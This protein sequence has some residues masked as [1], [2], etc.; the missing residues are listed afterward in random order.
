MFRRFIQEI[1]PRNGR[2]LMVLIV[3][4]IS[5]CQNQK[6]ASLDDQLDN[7]KALIREMYGDDRLVKFVVISTTGKGEHLDRSELT[8]V[9]TAMRS[10]IYD[11]TMYD[12]LSRLIRGEYAKTLLG[13]GKD[14]GTR[15]ISINDG[16]DTDDPTWEEDALT[17]CAENV[18]HQ[19]RTSMRIKQ[20]MMNRFKK[21]GGP[22]G[23]LLP[24][25]TA[26]EGAK[27]YMDWSK[28]DEMTPILQE[29][30][31]I[32]LRGERPNYGAVV[33]HFVEKNAP[34]GPY[35]R[36]GQWN[37]VM[38]RNL[39]ANPILKGWPERGKRR[40]VKHNESG[41]RPSQKNPEGGTPFHARHLA[42]FSE[43]VFDQLNAY[44]KAA[45]AHLGR[46]ASDGTLLLGRARGSSVFPGLHARCWYCGFHYVWGANGIPDKLMCRNVRARQ[47]WHSIG[48]SG[49][50]LTDRLSAE[51]CKELG[52]LDGFDEQFTALV[53]ESRRHV[54]DQFAD[55]WE[56][57]RRDETKFARDKDNLTASIKAAGPRPMLI[58][59]LDKIEI[60]EQK[61]L[62]RRHELENCSGRQLL[63]PPSTSALRQM[64]EDGLRELPAES[65]EFNDLLRKLVPEI[66]VYAVRMCD[67]GNLL[68]RAKVTLNLGG[69]FPDIN[70]VPGAADLLRR[71]LTID[72][73]DP[74]QRERIREE[75]ARSTAD[76]LTQRQIAATM[77][78]K[79]TIDMI[80]DA[81]AL[82]TR[83]DSLGITS[84]YVVMLEPPS[85]YPKLKR[86]LHA[87]YNFQ[88]REC[89]ERPPL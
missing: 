52:R 65:K 18:A 50:E 12:D 54:R 1:R 77:K 8:D 41:H 31:L 35:A 34:L 85:E 80:Q 38:V 58:E 39:Y 84:P 5:G 78:A 83:M 68:P 89:Y 26:P 15:S 47:C 51:I 53:A 30:R 27:T 3:C 13:I 42:H 28:I 66:Y 87:R 79:P 55:P 43:D 10:R 22:T 6:E 24:G 9:E 4:R 36:L 23:R 69:T 70:V 16:I 59:E 2:V 11:F 29:G 32:L 74:W 76:G 44:L 14:F 56:V 46:K 64:L 81:V 7:C 67:G 20:K 61:L 62:L 48:F 17:A 73:F 60:E 25:Y 75:V 21:T 88:S 45:N 49:A 86:H 33:D 63:L 37:E 71:E 72:L 57:L 19:T 82:Q 40:T